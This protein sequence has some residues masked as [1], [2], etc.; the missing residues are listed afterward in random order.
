MLGTSIGR[1]TAPTAIGHQRKLS[2]WRISLGS[3]GVRQVENL[4]D[5]ETFVARA[6]W[7][8]S[9]EYADV[10]GLCKVA[11]V[12]EIE[13]QGWSLNP[14]RYVGVA[15]R[16]E[17]DFDFKERLQEQNEELEM[18]NVEARGLEKRVLRRMW[19]CCWGGRDELDFQQL[20]R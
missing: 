14:G 9:A 2:F 10:A 8:C 7:R 13:A 15:E 17:E 3:I 5:S 1:L 12:A 11:T 4:H 16:E 6:F 19:V 18:L 20:S